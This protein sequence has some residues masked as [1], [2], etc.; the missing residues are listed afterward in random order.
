MSQTETK[1]EANARRQREYRARKRAELGDEAYLDARRVYRRDLTVRKKTEREAA[2]PVP[3]VQPVQAPE[4]YGKSVQKKLDEVVKLINDMGNKPGNEVRVRRVLDEIPEEVEKTSGQ[5][6]CADLIAKI[7]ARTGQAM[8]QQVSFIQNL[9]K[10]KFK[11]KSFDCTDFEWL[12]D[13]EG[14]FDFINNKMLVTRGERK[15]ELLAEVSKNG[16]RSHYTAILRELEGFENEHRRAQPD[17]YEQFKTK[18]EPITKSNKLS[19]SQEMNYLPHK[20]LQ[21]HLDHYP[22]GT[23]E[24]ALTSVYIDRPPRRLLDYKLMKVVRGDKNIRAGNVEK[25]STDFNYVI[26]NKQNIPKTFIFNVYKTVKNYKQQSIDISS[27]V[28]K[29]LGKYI[30]K[31]RINNGQYLFS[32]RRDHS[33]PVSDFSKYIKQTFEKAT[34]KAVTVN[35]IRHAF[36]TH[37]LKSDLTTFQKERLAEEM[38]HSVTVQDQYRVLDEPE[39]DASEEAEIRKVKQPQPEPAPKP[40]AKSVIVPAAEHHVQPAQPVKPPKPGRM[41]RSMARLS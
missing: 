4:G 40:A 14:I 22:E 16:Y 25:L 20:E 30:K 18:V 26:L 10:Q 6:S 24:N 38:A 34:G 41:T 17:L 9:Y 19:K 27:V 2:Q 23:A 39:T 21:K 3:I 37:A 15:G 1:S 36:I 31:E 13:V 33:A 8:D 7:K 5:K 35:L 28:A 11:K 29:K 32:K 12:R